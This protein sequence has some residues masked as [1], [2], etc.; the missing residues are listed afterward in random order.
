MV[1]E[2]FSF[3]A[4]WFQKEA[5]IFRPFVIN[6]YSKDNSVEI[7]DEKSGKMFLRRSQ[8][9]TLNAISHE[10]STMKKINVGAKFYIFGRQFNITDYADDYTKFKLS[11]H[12][13]SAFCL[14]KPDAIPLMDKIFN[15][16]REE[17]FNIVHCK[18]VQLDKECA[19]RLLMQ[20]MEDEPIQHTF[21]D[22]LSSAPI[23]VLE[24]L[25]QNAIQKLLHV[26]GP[27]DPN[28]AKQI[29]PNSI[30]AKYGT[31]LL[32]NVVFCPKSAVSNKMNIKYFFTDN[33]IEPYISMNG[34]LGV[35]KPHAVINENIGDII[36]LIYENNFS[37]TAMN[38]T[39]MERGDCEKFLEVYKGV[40]PGYNGYLWT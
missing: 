39:Y 17:R 20:E 3:K 33:R 6:V 38:M 8:L 29:C 10:H 40:I 2:R 9:E 1:S 13:E 21:V 7:F 14:L 37:I 35:I 25:S 36:S 11:S 5:D 16:F 27:N 24:L 30:R 22:Y 19:S 12:R 18:M 28:E 15:R 23:V 34:T 32:K 4:D 26:V 31:N